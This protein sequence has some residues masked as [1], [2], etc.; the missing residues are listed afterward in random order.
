M[1][2]H[3]HTEKELSNTEATHDSDARTSVRVRGC[4]ERPP[5]QER[6]VQRF[7]QHASVTFSMI[8]QCCAVHLCSLIL[9]LTMA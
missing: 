5:G 2:T 9:S 1:R 4:R 6:T 7:L 8:I 3:E